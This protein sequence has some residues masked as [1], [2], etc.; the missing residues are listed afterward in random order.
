M[1]YDPTQ[2]Y[3]E[4][5]NASWDRIR[6]E[7]ASSVRSEPADPSY[8]FNSFDYNFDQFPEL[9]PQQEDNY[10]PQEHQLLNLDYVP[11]IEREQNHQPLIDHNNLQNLQDLQPLDLE[12]ISYVPLELVS[13][14]EEVSEA[15]TDTD[16]DDEVDRPDIYCMECFSKIEDTNHHSL[17][18]CSKAKLQKYVCNF[19]EE[20][21][22]LEKNMKVHRVLVHSS[23]LDF[24]E[25]ITCPFCPKEPDQLVFSR[26][27]AFIGHLRV[28]VKTDVV[29]CDQCEIEFKNERELNRHIRRDH[30]EEVYEL[31]F[32]PK[33]Q[34]VVTLEE[35][36]AHL[37]LHLAEKKV[38]NAVKN[39]R[40]RKEPASK[41]LLSKLQPKKEPEAK[42]SHK[43]KKAVR[44]KK[45]QCEECEK[46]FVRP[47]ELAR[48]V[49]IHMRAKTS[50]PSTQ[51]GT[52]ETPLPSI[53]KWKCAICGKEYCHRAGLLEHNRMVHGKAKLSICQICGM[54]FTKKSN[55]SRHMLQ[56]HPVDQ[57]TNDQNKYPCSDCPT[58]FS[59]MGSLTR[60]KRICHR[61]TPHMKVK[62]V[63]PMYERHICKICKREFGEK[64]MLQMHKRLHLLSEYRWRDSQGGGER[65]CDFCDK[66]FVLRASLIWHL[67]KHYEEQQLEEEAEQEQPYCQLCDLHFYNRIEFRQHQDEQHS[68]V[69]GSC[70]LKFSSRQVYEDHICNRR[71]LS[72]NVNNQM[73]PNNRVLICRQCRPPQRLTTARQI[74]EHRARHLPRKTHLCWTCHK[75]F[76]T[77][78]LLSLHAEV[79]DRQPVQC[80]HCP[81]VFHSRVALKQH[82]RISHGGDTNYQCVVHVDR[83]MAMS[84]Q[85]FAEYGID[86]DHNDEQAHRA[87]SVTDWMDSAVPE[88]DPV[89]PEEIDSRYQP[90]MFNNTNQVAMNSIQNQ[91]RGGVADAPIRCELCHHLYNNLEMLCD[92]WQG[93]DTDTDHSY[94]FITCPICESRIRGASE[95]ANHLKNNHLFARPR[96]LQFIKPSPEN[97]PIPVSTD[98]LAL[99]VV[100]TTSSVMI[101]QTAIVQKGHQCVECSRTFTRRN[102]LNRHMKIHT[103]VKDF[104]CTECSRSFRTKSTLKSHMVTHSDNPP[105]FQCAVCQK[106]FYEKKA[107]VVHIRI[108]TG[109]QPHKCHFCDLHFR[110]ISMQKTHEKKCA[111]GGPHRPILPDPSTGTVSLFQPQYVAPEVDMN[112]TITQISSLPQHNLQL[113]RNSAFNTVQSME[114]MATSGDTSFYVITKPITPI[115]YVVIVQKTRPPEGTMRYAVDTVS[116]IKIHQLQESTNLSIVLHNEMRLN[117][118]TVRMLRMVTQLRMD[119]VFK[120]K[121][122]VGEDVPMMPNS[123]LFTIIAHNKTSGASSFIRR[124]EICEVDLP[125]KRASDAHFYSEDHETAQLM[126]PSK[127]QQP[128]MSVNRN[129]GMHNM[130][131]LNNE[132]SEFNCKLCG[133][134]FLDMNSLLNHIRREHDEPVIPP[135]PAA[136][137][138]PIN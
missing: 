129:L 137:T 68:V 10:V 103:G 91:G 46:A 3:R 84:A 66:S 79:H 133:S 13:E 9:I 111:Y 8:L 19:C 95:A 108:H 58:V 49:V 124:C 29:K 138:A 5:H 83:S 64:K 75:S 77:A 63:I 15:S 122:T 45:F 123:D 35:T 69:C 57:D 119:D 62:K 71:L 107:L 39:T 54:C 135:R 12:P 56:I 51:P 104:E 118:N 78:Q 127:N 7:N 109:E 25:Q 67:Q 100:P 40:K 116:E 34:K 11:I 128:A 131:P 120:A 105:Q 98:P 93:S 24:P 76:R 38:E 81:Q 59:I 43:K 87:H 89:H 16:E 18:V 74:K 6:H 94:G 37:L 22:N 88:E 114:K 130:I 115:Q 126:Y 27:T 99:A 23:K 4:R 31:S 121:V 82:N 20:E 117:L 70:H 90:M 97:I 86:A 26:F 36:P 50:K 112:R 65:K 47:S 72:R 101:P 96:L 33:C 42:V 21:F 125:T 102:D 106:S 44:I 30:F 80:A 55:L 132:T 61:K 32:C 134:R 110:T 53:P 1:D 85:S 60:H 92:H 14:E 41:N 2:Q 136:H 73:F 17:T 28:H 113:S 48:H 52:S